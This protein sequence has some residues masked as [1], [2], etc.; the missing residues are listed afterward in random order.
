MW[1][2]FLKWL[3]ASGWKYAA[4]AALCG[5]LWWAWGHQYNR[6]W[7]AGSAAQ[8]VKTAQVQNQFDSYK[9]AVASDIQKAEILAQQQKLQ[10]QTALASAQAALATAQKAEKA[11]NDQLQAI[12]SAAKPGDT[13]PLGPV[14][15]AYYQRLRGAPASP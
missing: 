8:A 1:P 3:L 6:G 2:L 7:A 11:K 13:R 9:L 14:A 10:L 5:A 12:L 4:G 15:S